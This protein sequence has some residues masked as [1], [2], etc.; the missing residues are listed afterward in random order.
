MTTSI[1]IKGPTVT[2]STRT[3]F[4]VQ[5]TGTHD[6]KLP[7]RGT[8]AIQEEISTGKRATP[9]EHGNST[10]GKDKARSA[11]AALSTKELTKSEE[12]GPMK[13]GRLDTSR[14]NGSA[15]DKEPTG[16]KDKN[17]VNGTDKGR[18]DSPRRKSEKRTLFASQKEEASESLR[19]PES[20]ESASKDSMTQ[21]G[22]EQAMV[23]GC[24]E[25]V[26][27]ENASNLE[28]RLGYFG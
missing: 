25:T 13:P 24:I 5:E 10:G 28:M 7:Y 26:D 27:N 17:P 18:K 19:Y 3:L 21:E 22:T 16:W 4:H 11:I 6:S 20:K 23:K 12:S 2:P 8:W 14:R 1:R 15:E 9:V